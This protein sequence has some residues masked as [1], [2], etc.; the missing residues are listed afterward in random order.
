MNSRQR[1]LTALDLQKPDKV[2]YMELWVD[3]SLGMRILDKTEKDNTKTK[4][5]NPPVGINKNFGFIGADYYSPQE[6]C[7]KLQMDAWGFVM[8]PIDFSNREESIT[9]EGK[10]AYITSGKIESMDDLKMIGLPDI[11]DMK[12]TYEYISN[13]L[14]KYK[15]DYAVFAFTY[16]G[17]EPVRRSF[18]IENFSYMLFDNI[19][20]IEETLDIY[21]EWL[22]EHNRILSELDFDFIW[23][24][25]DIAFKDGLLFPPDFY[26]DVCIPRFKKVVSVVSK[27]KVYHC[28]GNM[29]EVIEDLLSLGLNGLHPIEPLA[30]DIFEFKE[31]YGKRICTVGNI[32]LN[33]LSNGTPEE[34]Y[35]EV[36][37]KIVKLLKNGSYI[38][39]SSNSLTDYCDVNNIKSMVNAFSDF[40]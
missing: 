16:M 35:E 14:Q 7:E 15:K 9:K 4:K 19:K 33:I 13:Y 27:P 17:F 18:G 26:R 8:V 23:F 6:L 38:M 28:C 29:L 37:R 24:A 39:S 12:K 25:D 34:T 21:C 40:R 22:I 1:I 2:P 32:D 30:M 5:F 36:S 10:R 3:N 20:L 11:K 31:K